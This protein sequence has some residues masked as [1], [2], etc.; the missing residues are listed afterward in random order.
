MTDTIMVKL[1]GKKYP[2]HLVNGVQRFVPSPIVEAIV[3]N[4]IEVYSRLGYKRFKEL[5]IYG[6]NEISMD[7]QLGKYTVQEMLDFH[8][9]HG[10]SVSGMLDLS[11]FEDVEVENPLWED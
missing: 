8:T 11:F 1:D 4:Q 5:G 6:L 10:Y 3:S 2:T 9:S 7:F